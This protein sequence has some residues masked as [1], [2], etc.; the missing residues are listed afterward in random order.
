MP[1]RRKKHRVWEERTC[2][3]SQGGSSGATLEAP[4]FTTLL[5]EFY[6]A[7][8]TSLVLAVRISRVKAGDAWIFGRLR[9]VAVH[10]SSRAGDR[11]WAPASRHRGCHGQDARRRERITSSGRA[12]YATS[13][14]VLG[15]GTPRGAHRPPPCPHGAQPALPFLR[16]VCMGALVRA[17]EPLLLRLANVMPQRG[18]RPRA[19]TAEEPAPV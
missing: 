13:V 5:R 18:R 3:I 6:G 1:C 9:L 2:A 8:M 12:Q 7:F 19:D 16:L 11:A 10:T 17:E 15:S 14:L 4:S